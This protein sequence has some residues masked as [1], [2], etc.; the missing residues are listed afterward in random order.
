M[1]VVAALLILVSL[2]VFLLTVDWLTSSRQ[3][4]REAAHDRATETLFTAMREDQC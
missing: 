4:R 1:T 3:H 2:P